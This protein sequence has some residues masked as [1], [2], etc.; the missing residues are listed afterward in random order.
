MAENKIKIDNIIKINDIVSR[1][2][3]THDEY[4]KIKDTL[5]EMRDRL[6]ELELKRLELQKELSSIRLEEVNFLNELRNNSPEEY[7]ELMVTIS[8][9]AIGQDDDCDK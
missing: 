2:N 8:R 4:A 7:Q 1:Y 5:L 3:T 6:A 9:K